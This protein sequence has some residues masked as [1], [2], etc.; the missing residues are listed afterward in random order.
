MNIKRDEKAI[1]NGKFASRKIGYFL[2]VFLIL[3]LPQMN[4]TNGI[5]NQ[6]ASKIIEPKLDK[7]VLKSKNPIDDYG[8]FIAEISRWNEIQD[9]VA[10]ELDVNGDIAVFDDDQLVGMVILNISNPIN[11]EFIDIFPEFS[12]LLD[13]I[14]EETRIYVS[15]NE[16]GVEVISIDDI[17]NPI[18]LG[19]N[20]QGSLYAPLRIERKDDLIYAAT[21]FDDLVVYNVSD[22]SNITI[23]GSYENPTSGAYGI[24]LCIVDNLV[25]LADRNGGLV[26]LNISNP[27]NPVK[28][29]ETYSGEFVN[30][31]VVHNN[32]AYINCV[33]EEPHKIAIIDVTDPTNPQLITELEGIFANINE[34][35]IEN[36]CL[37]VASR[38]LRIYNIT[39]PANPIEIASYD[40]DLFTNDMNVVNQFYYL[41][42]SR[43]G[44]QILGPDDDNEGLANYLETNIYNTDPLNKDSDKDRMTD[45]KEILKGNNPLKWDNW[46]LL[47]GVYFIPIHLSIVGLLVF[48]FLKYR[49]K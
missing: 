38:I 36:N 17:N 5:V 39:Q 12:G 2:I 49:K 47:F 15:H 43:G 21:Q 9:F 19:N 40:K 41:T 46:T 35:I 22:P 11:P 34:L 10:D 37:Y 48:I 16:R 44:F 3:V 30:A 26:I 31:V 1:F 45:Y 33:G 24:D 18:S 8:N 20:S 7:L 13:I 4:S 29:G 32:V 6:K 23:V 42:N 27:N 28:I 25:Y 14:V